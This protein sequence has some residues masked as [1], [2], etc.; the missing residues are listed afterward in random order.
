LLLAEV[1]ELIED[2]FEGW[3]VTEEHEARTMETTDSWYNYREQGQVKLRTA[4]H[5]K[6]RLIHR[7]IVALVCPFEFLL[8]E[9]RSAVTEEEEGGEEEEEDEEGEEEEEGEAGDVGNGASS[10]VSRSFNFTR[11]HLLEGSAL[12]RTIDKACLGQIA[13]DPECRVDKEFVKNGMWAAMFVMGTLHF[14]CPFR[15]LFSLPFRPFFRFPKPRVDIPLAFVHFLCNTCCLDLCGA[16]FNNCQT[17]QHYKSSH[18]FVKDK[19]VGNRSSVCI[20]IDANR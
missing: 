2:F 10:M 1:L 4:T 15:F 11:E 6:L 5:T 14:F 7:N 9:I 12:A 17:G 19:P 20:C 3:D 18:V 8:R 16:R 13:L